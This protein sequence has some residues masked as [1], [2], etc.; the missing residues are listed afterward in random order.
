MECKSTVSSLEL[1]EYTFTTDNNCNYIGSINV[2]E[3][4]DFYVEAQVTAYTD[5]SFGS[6]SIYVFGGTEPFTYL[7][8]GDTITN[9]TSELNSGS[10]TLTSLMETVAF[11]KKP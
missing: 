11:K 9:Y 7:L 2:Y 3:M 10:Y 8:N 4:E 1:Y 5:T 6:I